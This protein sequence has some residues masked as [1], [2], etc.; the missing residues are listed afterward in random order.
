MEKEIIYKRTF[1]GSLGRL[2]K[3]NEFEPDHLGIYYGQA[4]KYVNEH[5][6]GY[7]IDNPIEWM[8]WNAKML[9]DI[10][11][12]RFCEWSDEKA[13]PI[14]LEVKLTINHKEK[15]KIHKISKNIKKKCRRLKYKMINIWHI[16]IE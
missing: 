12:E 14:K 7:W 10:F 11:G 6:T 1:K 15:S 4:T 3:D 9:E 13:L 8:P 2:S 5:G 16:I